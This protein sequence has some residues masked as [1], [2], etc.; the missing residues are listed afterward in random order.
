MS[1]DINHLTALA[2][3]RWDEAWTIET[4]QFADGDSQSIAFH[5]NGVVDTDEY[6]EPLIERERLMIGADGCVSHDRVWVRQQSIVDVREQ[7]TLAAPFGD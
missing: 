7:E 1:E 5:S 2:R 6:D 4:L 3:D